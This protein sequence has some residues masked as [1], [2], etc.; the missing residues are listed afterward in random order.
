MTIEASILL[1]GEGRRFN[2]TML[3]A[4]MQQPSSIDFCAAGKL[5]PQQECEL[6]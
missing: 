1:G 3:E 4:G 2:R 6:G 5:L